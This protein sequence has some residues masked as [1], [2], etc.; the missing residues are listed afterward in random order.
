MK[1]EKTLTKTKTS[2]EPLNKAQN[3]PKDKKS[4]GKVDLKKSNSKPVIGKSD[5]TD[6]PK[7]K[8]ENKKKDNKEDTKENVENNNKNTQDEEKNK[9]N[10]INAQESINNV[11]IPNPE[12]EPETRHDKKEDEEIK[13]FEKVKEKININKTITDNFS[14]IFIFFNKNDVLKMKLVNKSYYKLSISN[15]LST[16]RTDV[17]SFEEKVTALKDKNNEEELN[18]A[19]QEFS[20]GRSAAKALDLLNQDKYKEIFKNDK[21]PND[22]IILPYKIFFTLLNK[23]E[24][25]IEDNAEFWKEC[26]KFMLS[27][28]KTGELVTNYIKSF[29]FS[30]E[31]L[32]RLSRICSSKEKKLTPNFYSKVCSTTGIIIFLIK[33]VIEYIG[34]V[35]DKKSMPTPNRLYRYYK[36]VC[37]QGNNRIEKLKESE[38]KY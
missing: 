22:D 6:G 9:Q 1:K 7:P 29:E 28:A 18:K 31:I 36:A 16:L 26:S 2:K 32:Y 4:E 25:K 30:N 35:Q 27:E 11:V 14:K 3:D 24:G 5:K 33:D 15:I 21:I 19:I 37:E 20:L 13:I 23:K 8:K 38:S 34:I 12:P 17:K 10:C